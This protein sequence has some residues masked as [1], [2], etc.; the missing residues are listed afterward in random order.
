MTLPPNLIIFCESQKILVARGYCTCGV[1]IV[2]FY[3]WD[4]ADVDDLSAT[5]WLGLLRFEPFRE[6]H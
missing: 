2:M 5:I 4:K 1:A 6:N 3:Y